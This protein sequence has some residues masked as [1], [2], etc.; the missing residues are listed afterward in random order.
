[1]RRT[2]KTA[3]PDLLVDPAMA[4]TPS[5]WCTTLP[6]VTAT[7]G[8][9]SAGWGRETVVAGTLRGTRAGYRPKRSHRARRT[10]PRPGP[11]GEFRSGPLRPRPQHG[12]A[13]RR[14]TAGRSPDHGNHALRAADDFALSAAWCPKDGC[15]SHQRAPTTT[16]RMGAHGGQCSQASS[17]SGGLPSVDGPPCPKMRTGPLE[18]GPRVVKL[19]PNVTCAACRRRRDSHSRLW[20]ADGQANV[21]PVGRRGPNVAAPAM[22]SNWWTP[23]V[24]PSV[25]VV[26]A[27]AGHASAGMGHRLLR[28][29]LN[30]RVK[31]TKPNWALPAIAQSH[32]LCAGDVLVLTRTP[33]G[34]SLEPRAAGECPDRLH[35]TGRIRRRPRRPAGDTRRWK[36]T[37]LID[38]SP[39]A[40]FASGSS[41]LQ[42]RALGCVP[43]KDQ[44]SDTE[45]AAAAV[46]DADMPLLEV[47][48]V[49]AT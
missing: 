19:R 46:S 4:W 39:T 33:P 9:C 45:L 2:E 17:M 28:Q 14:P 44:P 29:V 5:T 38:G 37:G 1:M 3:S 12:R 27:Q 43:R 36:M 47:A 25:H 23:R 21:V 30:C 7:S 13:F 49:H 42:P 8:T 15:G 48:A 22:S 40:N 31:A 34:R 20:R 26:E 11:T 24:G 10:E 35:A 41:P 18:D 16:Q 32:R 6:F